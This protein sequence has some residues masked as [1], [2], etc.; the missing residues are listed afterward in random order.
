MSKLAFVSLYFHSL[1]SKN[2]L[3]IPARFRDQLGERFYIMPGAD[4]NLFVYPQETFEDIAEQYRKTHRSVKQ[5]TA[6]FSKVSEA[7][8]DNQGRV[9]LEGRHVEH[10]GLV[11][12]IA[13]VGAGRRVEIWPMEKFKITQDDAENTIDF[14]E[15]IDW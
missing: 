14:S 2:R 11:K 3:F 7:T 5:Q 13:V 1:D 15:D 9:T 8:V 10:A 6:F 12:E 4:S